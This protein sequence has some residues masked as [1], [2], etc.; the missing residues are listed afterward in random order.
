MLETW[1]KSTKIMGSFE[2]LEYRFCSYC[3]DFKNL[4]DPHADSDT[5][6]F[7]KE[8]IFTMEKS[9]RETATLR[10][11]GICRLRGEVRLWQGTTVHVNGSRRTARDWVV[12]WRAGS[13]MKSRMITGGP[14]R[15]GT[16]ESWS[17][18]RSER[19]KMIWRVSRFVARWGC[20]LLGRTTTRRRMSVWQL[21]SKPLGGAI[22]V[23]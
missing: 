22:I 4:S 6:Q 14:W 11:T 21:H 2:I 20:V 12:C 9:A 10:G 5:V 7:N 23:F 1:I 18:M 8:F 3:H 17:N 13:L 16:K 19:T 15:Q